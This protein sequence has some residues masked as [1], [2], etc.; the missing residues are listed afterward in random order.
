MMQ[1]FGFLKGTENIDD[2]FAALSAQSIDAKLLTKG[3]HQAKLIKEFESRYG[4]SLFTL[5][6]TAANAEAH[7]ED[8]FDT[9]LKR[10]FRATR[11]KPATTT[12]T[13]QL[14]VSMVKSATCKDLIPSKQ[15][16]AK[17]DRG[18][19]RLHLKRRAPQISPR[20]KRL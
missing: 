15:L 16:K 18:Q 4:L 13:K 7:L 20:A 8:N 2:H 12:D 17:K 5:G 10:V 14:Y 3:Y 6:E 11:A 1:P 19:T 9:V